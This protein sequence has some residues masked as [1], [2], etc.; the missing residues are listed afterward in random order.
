MFVNGIVQQFEDLGLMQIAKLFC[1]LTLMWNSNADELV[2]FAVLPLARFEEP[3]KER[4][5]LWIDEWLQ[6]QFD[7]LR[8]VT[9]ARL[10][11]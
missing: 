2:A 8:R 6:S 9:A 5:L 4:G 1:D 11:A 10:C 3:R 7:I